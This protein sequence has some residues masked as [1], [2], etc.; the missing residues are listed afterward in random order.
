MAKNHVAGRPRSHDVD[1]AILSAAID[2]LASGGP[3]GVTINAVARRSGVARA[4]IYLRYP[5]RD[6]LLAATLRAAI[7]REPF[8]LSGDLLTD[9]RQ[10]AIQA[11]AILA[12]PQFR[13]VLPE[14]VRALLRQREGADAVTWDLVGPNLGRIADEY[15]RLAAAAGLRTDVDPD[16]IGRTIV[17]AL[18]MALLDKGVAPSRHD[19][20]QTVEI[21]LEGFKAR[22]GSPA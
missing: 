5:G 4:S 13:V 1:V 2:L 10:G 6:A 9:L 16:L 15:P 8:A 12:H 14:I 11:Q 7:G 19:A 20:E 18:L 21:I 22:G 17:G 3:A